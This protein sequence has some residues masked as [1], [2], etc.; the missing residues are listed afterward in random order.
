MQ[1]GIAISFI[2]MKGIKI[3][4]DGKSAELQPGLT[5]G[6]LIRYLWA[7]GK[8]TVTGN[9]L[10]TGI[11]GIM[12]GGGHG[13]LQGLFGLLADQILEARVVLADGSSVVASPSSNKDLF[14][15]L[16]GAGHNFGIITGLRYKIYDAIPEW[17]EVNV[18]FTQDKLEKV[19]DLANTL[20][21]EETH[22]AELIAWFTLMRRPDI[23][24][25]SVS[26]PSY[27]PVIFFFYLVKDSNV[28]I[29]RPSSTSTS[30]TPAISP[31][32]PVSPLLSGHSVPPDKP[33][34]ATSNT[35][36]YSSST[37]TTKPVRKPVARGCFATCSR[38]T[39]LGITPLLS[40]K[41]I[42]F[43]QTLPRNI[44]ASRLS[45]FMFWKDIPTK[46]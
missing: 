32:S 20:V 27:S 13:Y 23:D 6:E 36:S 43:S 31:P 29:Y 45:P 42:A 11:M 3:N 40:G 18:V 30:F 34:T 19:F 1:R 5:N 16:R 41:S 2:K 4:A 7:N 46:P 10:C 14:W 21:S 33:T 26:T 22:P 12:L 15:A 28:Y 17:S 38:R 44:P 9:C 39:C 35:Q 25:S 24:N 8:Q 37:A